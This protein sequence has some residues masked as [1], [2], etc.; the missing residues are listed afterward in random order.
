MPY[1]TPSYQAPEQSLAQEY[2]STVDVFAVSITAFIML[3]GY[4]PFY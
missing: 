4:H 3:V 2:D 1:G